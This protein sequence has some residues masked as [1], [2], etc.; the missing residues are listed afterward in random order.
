MKLRSHYLVGAAA[1][2]AIAGAAVSPFAHHAGA[3][4]PTITDVTIAAKNFSVS[5][6]ATIP[7]GLVR[8][9][10]TGVTNPMGTTAMVGAFRAGTTQAAVI[11][12]LNKGDFGPMLKALL[13]VG[14]PAVAGAS[15]GSDI[16]TLKAGKYVVFNIEQDAK[17]KSHAVYKFFDVSPSSTPVVE[18][19]SNAT[20]NELDMKFRVPA[21]IAAGEVTLKIVNKG[22]SIHET[23]LAKL[24]AGTT[25]KALEN[26][27][28]QQNP[29]GPPPADFV[30]LASAM[31]PGLTQYASTNLTSGTYVLICFMPDKHGLPHVADGMIKSFNVR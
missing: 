31:A 9:T 19:A 17:G 14:G 3:A 5:A 12:V 21:S 7:A 2:V 24:H 28:K 16:L 4:A 30:G 27:L 29:S 18:P 20:I 15:A 8:F 25:V 22:P 10:L 23:V 13:P 26:Y 11:S 6:P 1:V